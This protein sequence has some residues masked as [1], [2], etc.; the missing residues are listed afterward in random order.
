MLLVGAGECGARAA[1]ALREAGYDGPVR[2][3]GAEDE[4]PYERP[5]LSKAALVGGA[6]PQPATIADRARLAAAGIEFLS[7]LAVAAIDR[8]ARTAVLADGRRL[9]YDRLLLATGARARRLALPGAEH[10]HLLRSIA[11]A[12]ALHARLV[13]GAR[14]GIIGGGFIGLELAASATARGC[15]VTVVEMAPRV[16]GRAV[17]E[18]IAAVVAARHRAAGVRLICAATVAAVEAGAILLGSGE[19][20]GCDLVIAGVG[21]VPETALAEAAGLA[22]E[23]GVRVD[24]RLATADPDI[25][26]AGDCCSFPHPLFG[27]RRIRLES[28]RNAQDQG[29]FAARA[30]LGA[31]E[32]FATPPWFWSDQYDLTLQIAGLPDAAE[33]E[34]V[35]ERED[36]VALRFGLDAAGRLVAAAAVG[37]GDAVARDIRLAEMMIA[38]R[39]VP[40]PDRLADPA[41]G[42]KKLLRA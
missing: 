17:P 39:A 33:R 10:A 29:A 27:G 37:P 12:R 15:A 22:V 2:L 40:D 11:D 21:A 31:A 25:F 26:A 3:V 32:E 28:W 16:L 18:P 20:L 19:R 24:G 30:M 41:T 6:E 4:A 8:P 7:G 36:G 9:A 14:V 38:A 34:V 42:L 23:N 13:P 1:L 5:P 35:R